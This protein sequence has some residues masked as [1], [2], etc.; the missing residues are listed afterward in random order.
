MSHFFVD[1]VY[2][3]GLIL[4]LT[5]FCKLFTNAVERF[6]ENFS[7]S[8]N[9][10]GNL[11]AAI[12]TALPET[13]LPIVAVLGAYVSGNNVEIG[14]EICK[15]SVLG[16]MFFLSTIGFF[17]IAITVKITFLLRK[18]KTPEIMVNTDLFRK[19]LMFFL[20]SYGIGITALFSSNV[21]IM[22]SCGII[23]PLL[24]VFFVRKNLFWGNDCSSAD[25]NKQ[26]ALIFEKIFRNFLP[27]TTVIFLQILFSLSGIILSTHLFAGITAHIASDFG[28]SALIATIFIAPF[29]TELPETVNAII[30]SSESKDELSVGNITGALMFQSCFPLCTALLLT[31]GL[32][33]EEAFLNV[34]LVILS[35]TVLLFSIKKDKCSISTNMLLP[36]GFLY[37]FYFIF[38][39]ITRNG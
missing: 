38:L 39:L 12:G 28:I 7:V 34:L 31:D 23:L 16:S 2:I 9:A 21:F 25:D 32:R 15:G 20:T 27:Q 5:L 14:C 10:L 3:S 22:K 19:N 24:Y 35:I 33:S 1:V 36:S 11:F 4:L 13:A 8:N 30:W 37:L 29:A 18:R 26:N 17:I 6:G